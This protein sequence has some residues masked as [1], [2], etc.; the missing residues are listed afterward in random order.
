MGTLNNEQQDMK[1]P[2]TD[3]KEKV[4]DVLGSTEFSVKSTIIAQKV[5]YQEGEDLDKVA[6]T[7]IHKALSLPKIGIVCTARINGCETGSGIVK[8]ELLSPEDAKKVL[9][10]KRE[11]KNN[12]VKEI[13]D[14]YLRHSKKD[15]VRLMEHNVDL[16]LR[17]MGVHD[18]YVHLPSGHLVKKAEYGTGKRGGCGAT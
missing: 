14:I 11:L 16:I 6:K 15:E 9:Q 17:E 13:H 3:I 8:I 2:L 18:D 4:E 12:P 5:W 10:N 7:I 1:T